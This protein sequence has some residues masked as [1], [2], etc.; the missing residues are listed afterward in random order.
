MTYLKCE[1]FF[2]KCHFS[3]LCADSVL[4]FE[5]VV[6]IVLNIKCVYNVLCISFAHVEEEKY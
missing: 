6:Y 3:C 1:V 4:P 5:A 2:L